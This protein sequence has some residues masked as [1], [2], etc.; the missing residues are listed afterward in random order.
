MNESPIFSPKILGEHCEMSVTEAL[1]SIVTSP[2]VQWRCWMTQI[3]FDRCHCCLAI[4]IN[5]YLL[6]RCFSFRYVF[7][8]QISPQE[9]AL[10][11]PRVL[12]DWSQKST[13]GSSWY[14]PASSSHDPTWSPKWRSLSPWKGHLKQTTKVAG[15]EPGRYISYI[16]LE[17]PPTQ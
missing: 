4:Q 7:R 15:N 5:K 6:G 9:M 1:L 13:G 16:I 3:F 10:D 11:G 2:E 14:V 17:L 8:V 12:M